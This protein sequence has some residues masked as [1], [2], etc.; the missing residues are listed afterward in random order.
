MSNNPETA[1]TPVAPEA[2]AGSDYSAASI[3]VLEGLEAVRKRP[4][5]YIGPPD[6][7][8]MHHLVWE[9]VDN[10]VDE[11]LAGH[12]T[13]IDVTVH[14]DNAISVSDNGRGI[15]TEMHPTEGRPTPE[16]VLTVL[17]A[18]GKFDNNSYKVSGGLHGV[19]VSCVNALSEYLD[20]EIARGGKLYH[21]TYARG[22]PTS[23]LAVTGE[24]K[25]TGTKIKFKPDLEIFGERD[26]NFDTLAQRLRELAFLN[27]GL[28]I[29]LTDERTGKSHD[30]VYEGGI[31]SFVEHLNRNK[32][33]LFDKPVHVMQEV[34]AGG[35]RVGVEIALQY[36]DTYDDLVFTF[37]NNIN[38]RD[39]GAHLV[40]FKGAL[41]RTVNN[42]ATK[43]NLWKDLKESPSG[44]D[45]REGLCAVISVKLPNPQFDSQTKGKLINPEIKG[46]VEA[47]V[48]DRLGQFFEENP[49]V[50]KRIA[51]K[52]GDA[53]R[54][55][56]AARKAR[57]TVRRKGAL[58]TA[59]L[60][61]KLADCQE[62]DPAKSELYIVEG[63]SAGGSAKQGRDRR[64]Q[65]ILPLRGK[66]LNVEK[67]RFDKM[68]SSAEI[69]TLITALGTGIGREDYNPDKA[70]YHSIILMSV[71]GREPVFVRGGQTSST[72]GEVRQVRIGEFIDGAL[73]QHPA[74]EEGSYSA[75]TN[76]SD[77]APLGEVLCFGLEDHQLRFRPIRKV[78]RHEVTEPL[79][80]IRTAYGRSVRVT[81]SHSVF[82]FVD[83]EVVLKRGDEIRPGDRVVAPRTMP[84]PEQAPERIDLLRALHRVPQAA[85][86]VWVRGAGV[87]AFFQERVR[88]E[89]AD[90]PDY[91]EARVEIPADVRAELAALRRGKVGK[92]ELCQRIG[93]RQPV[94]FYGW[95]KG[96]SRPTVTHFDRWL[97][98]IGAD[99]ESYRARVQVG[100][101]R[102][103]R[104][105]EEQGA[106]KNRVKPYVRL[107]ALEAEDVE[108][109]ASRDD[110]ELTPEHY[111]DQ[112]I[113]RFVD[114][115]P[116]LMKLLGFFVAE[117]S[118]SDRN[119]IRLTIGKGNARFLGEFADSIEH[120]FGIQPTVYESPDRAGTLSLVNRVAALVFQHV[121]GFAGADSLT[122]RIPDLVFNVSRDLR[123]A[124][125]RGFLLGDGTATSGR[126]VLYTSSPDLAAGLLSLLASLG[127][128]ASHS[129][130][131]PDGVE[132]EIRGSAVVT[133]ADHHQ[134][135][136]AAREDLAAIESA[137]RDHAG[138]ESIR[139][140]LASEAPSVNRR[141]EAIDG[142]LVALPV[143]SV[144]EVE[145]SNGFVYDFSVDGDENFVAGIGGIC[146][147][148]T[149]ADVD[150]SHI[151]TLL[152]TF[153]YRQMPE[154]VERGYLYIAQP[155]LYKVQKGKRET[156]LKDQRALDEYLMDMGVAGCTLHTPD[157]DRTGEALKAIAR[158]ILDY[159]TLIA[160]VDRRRDGRVVDS[161]VQA[162]AIDQ[163]LLQDRAAL[164]AELGKLQSWVEQHHA[165]A[166]PLQ[167]FVGDDEEHG[168]K[169][170]TVRSHGAGTWRETVLDYAFLGS[171][172]AQELRRFGA[173]FAALGEAPYRMSVGSGEAEARSVQ[174]V[175]D[176]IN[177][178]AAKGQSIQRYKGLG[179]MNP[180]QLWETT[181]NPATR[182]LLQVRVDD[183]VEADQIFTVLMGDAVEPRRDFIEKNA[184]EVQNLDV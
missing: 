148:N 3:T 11:A 93:I 61:G 41:T 76:F 163:A 147:H 142:D 5:M 89:Y 26:Y 52:V 97:E 181:M 128:T 103:E 150:G 63:D 182:T 21:Q 170:V 152:L 83:G 144:T 156:Y 58:D 176:L 84:L 139:Q 100:P 22:V 141:F 36:N 165:E 98:A 50:A 31:A 132:R 115:S 34:D 2:A 6:E 88:A 126:V 149:D 107:S 78:I 29:T 91:S 102:L 118:V 56:I 140:R 12:C 46:V 35:L 131:A 127:A 72:T 25:R 79:Y 143:E 129:I 69:A 18:G 146:C 113:R 134:L 116:E 173:E 14:V 137:W 54:A 59:S 95:E 9:V 65:A 105:W 73:A 68:L 111:A 166:M 49:Q 19:G 10:S 8:G 4:G 40:G 160:K 167:F 133:R 16:V 7:T 23:E 71:D 109:L 171:P 112:A 85:S 81:A 106:A 177:K 67:A 62:R 27:A 94:T 55:R 48:Y 169:R 124:F 108:W 28:Q 180:E 60:P 122:K 96:T 47:V 117:G 178:D 87:Q 157:G 158:R 138:A 168:C 162:T 17:H 33:L 99:V 64:T 151:R 154:L 20:L 174:Q 57:E 80:E 43:N 179:E 183:A 30:F 135:T 153:F 121:F 130:R 45:A 101:S 90:R 24:A 155:P 38:T 120:V 104:V 32:S 15:P 110:V 86:Q 77:G 53:A 1:A 159:R 161:M 42:Y 136:V 125:L 164:E 92:A 37:A 82:A 75:L 114:V 184:L 123:L 74:A 44:E 175:L 119:G 13:R 51:Q 145:A 66:I 70:R 39:G 172:E